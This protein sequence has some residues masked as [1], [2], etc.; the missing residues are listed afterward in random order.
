MYVICRNPA[1]QE[2]APIVAGALEQAV[3]ERRILDLLLLQ[4]VRINADRAESGNPSWAA[5]TRDP[6]VTRALAALH[7]EPA[8]PW[9]VAELALRCHVS[10][11]TMAA[12]FRAAVGQSPM[13]YLTTW[14]LV[15]AADRLASS[16]VT[17]AVI[18]E[19]VG[20]SNAFT[21]SAAFSREY[22][23]ARVG[24][25]GPRPSLPG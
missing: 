16:A 9:T 19:E 22:G 15:L 11:A 2:L 25:A 7:Q 18:A 17:T 23:S 1:P 12:R 13:A 5:G 3:V 6:I 10:R 4:L 21:F 20:Y 8:A 24:T 14:R